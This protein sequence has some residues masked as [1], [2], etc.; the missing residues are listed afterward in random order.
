MRSE[1]PGDGSQ[2]PG[3][4]RNPEPETLSPSP[5]RPLTPAPTLTTLQ[6][7]LP[8]DFGAPGN[9]LHPNFV[10]DPLGRR[11]LVVDYP[12]SRTYLYNLEK[13]GERLVLGQPELVAAL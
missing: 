2:G 7:A 9:W 8:Y 12:R 4:T 6:F 3:R 13:S 11:L 5:P 1:E 10:C